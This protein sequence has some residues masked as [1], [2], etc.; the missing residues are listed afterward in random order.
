MQNQRNFLD[1]DKILGKWQT[2]R[3]IL[4]KLH[5]TKFVYFGEMTI[6]SNSKKQ[7]AFTQQQNNRFSLFDV[8]ESGILKQNGND[9]AFS[10]TYQLKVFFEKCD[11]LFNNEKLF[12]SFKRIAENQKIEHSCILDQYSGQIIFTGLSSFMITFNVS[13]PKK[14]YYLKALYRR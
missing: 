3:V 14:Q 13:G 7:I 9:Y 10:Q 1:T 5:V 12:F 2:K 11:I 6:V 4:D 8:K